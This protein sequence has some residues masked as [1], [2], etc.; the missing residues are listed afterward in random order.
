[1]QKPGLIN[2]MIVTLVVVL[3]S[4]FTFEVLPV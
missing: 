4:V 2:W 1:M 3:V